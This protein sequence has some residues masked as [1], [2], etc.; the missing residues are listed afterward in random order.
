MPLTRQEVLH[1][2]TLCRIGMT[3]EEIERFGEQLSNILEQFEVLKQVDT[4]GIPPT[5]QSIE[6]HGVF[7]DDAAKPSLSKEETLRNA[8]LREGDYFRVKAVLEE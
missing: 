8:P 6:L 5:A 7:R 2:A 4:E 3:E 1:I